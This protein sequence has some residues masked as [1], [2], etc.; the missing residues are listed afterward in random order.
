MNIKIVLYLYPIRF[1]I[2]IVQFENSPTA[3]TALILSIYGKL[4]IN[5][6]QGKLMGFVFVSFSSYSIWSYVNKLVSVINILVGFPC[7]HVDRVVKPTSF[8]II[9]RILL[10]A[11]VGITS[12][13]NAQFRCQIKYLKDFSFYSCR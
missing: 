13:M 3:D 12:R 4:L 6:P 2:L 8:C 5:P 7:R 10:E 9:I 11:R 1:Y